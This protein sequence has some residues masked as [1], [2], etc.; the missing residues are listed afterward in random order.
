MIFLPKEGAYGTLYLYHQPWGDWGAVT[1]SGN[2]YHQHGTK[3]TLEELRAYA[4]TLL[5]AKDWPRVEC[6]AA[7]LKMNPCIR[8]EFEYED[9]RIQRLT[10]EAAQAWL[11]NVDNIVGGCEIRYGQTQM[12]DHPWTF[13]RKEAPDDND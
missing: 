9:G 8:V 11:K 13:F 4:D 12:N 7:T 1:W 5:W 2:Q 6:K 3:K 10:G